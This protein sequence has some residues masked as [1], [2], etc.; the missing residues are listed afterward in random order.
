MNNEINNSGY[1]KLKDSPLILN[2]KSPNQIRIM[3]ANNYGTTVWQGESSKAP[4]ILLRA[5][6]IHFYQYVQWNIY[7]INDLREDLTSQIKLSLLASRMY[8]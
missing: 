6:N 8:I 3:K 4:F 2:I 5:T 7:W 1:S